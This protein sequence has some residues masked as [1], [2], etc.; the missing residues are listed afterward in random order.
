MRTNIRIFHL[1]FVLTSILCAQPNVPTFNDTVGGVT[2]RLLGED[3]A[4]GG[5]TTIA[6]V[7]VPINLSFEAK[8]SNGKPFIMDAAPDVPRVLESPVFSKFTFPSG[9]ET[10]Y[11]DA[12]LRS[13][14]P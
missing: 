6:T 11:L 8:K 5:T 2:Y 10:Q 4:R 3:P 9:G 1:A 14:L 7:L 12:M 13:T